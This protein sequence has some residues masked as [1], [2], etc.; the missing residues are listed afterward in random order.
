[1]QELTQK[2][3]TAMVCTVI[4]ASLA[5]T[6][7]GAEEPSI[8]AREFK[9]K[10]VGTMLY[11]IY[12]PANYNPKIKYPLVLCLHGGGG[13]G[14]DN[15]S[16][17]T[18]AYTV[19]SSSDVQK[20]YPA[21]LMTPQCPKTGKWAN[22]SPKET[23]SILKVPMTKE[24]KL[25]LEILDSLQNEFSIDPA[26]L[27]VTGQS[28]GG[29]G[30]WDIILRNPNLF[31]AAVPVCGNNDPSQAKKVIHLPIW[32]FHGEKDKTVPTK[33]SRDIVAALKKAGSKVKY[34][35][36]P[37]VGHNS[38]TP[39]WSEKDLIPWLFKQHKSMVAKDDSTPVVTENRVVNEIGQPPSPPPGW[40]DGYIMANGLRI[41][42]WRT[43]GDKPVLLMAHG[44]S[45]YGLCWTNL[46]KEL[47]GDYDIIMADARGHGYSDPPSK[48]DPADAQTEDLADLIR[49][50]KLEQPIMMGHSMGSSSVA[51]FAA[52]Y[53]DIPR[54]VILVDPRLIPRPPRDSRA[55]NNTD[56]QDKRRAQILERNNMT[57]EELVALCMKNNAQWERPEIEFWALSKRLHHPNT[58]FRSRGGSP[59]KSE[60]FARITAPTLILKADAEG[61]VRM[62][63][64]EVAGLLN[65]GR[66]VH[67]E[68]AGHS[69]HRDQKERLLKALKAFLGEL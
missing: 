38:W 60:L 69:V 15:K 29:A 22:E 36:Y 9:S 16:R 8:E 39:A 56:A 20:A 28:M 24:M 59:E 21:F 34:T 1:M 47:E 19:L 41:H 42:Y 2:I 6:N 44:S 52:R 67:V 13:R 37:G 50:L 48:S 51:W 32:V 46:S 11:R 54:A 31:A 53:P 3:S 27:Y 58:A 7:A 17:G 49:E 55:T 45:D 26:R 12:K 65:N 43:G 62:Q 40:A 4:L 30:T 68:G 64:E 18:H 61:D 35:E 23:Y 25:V 33:S 5:F 66:I 57:Y 10:S 14:N 63:N